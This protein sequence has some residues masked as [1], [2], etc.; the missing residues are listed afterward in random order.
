MLL[1]FS[2]STT[3]YLDKKSIIDFVTFEIKGG[4]NDVKNVIECLN[5]NFTQFF[6]YCR[7]NQVVKEFKKDYTD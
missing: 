4:V 5:Y 1:E 6:E 3:E 2:R 7:V